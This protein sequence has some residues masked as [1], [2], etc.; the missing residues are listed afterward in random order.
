MSRTS[1]ISLD[2]ETYGIAERT[3]DGRPLPP[4][5]VFHPARAIRTDG[6]TIDDMILT[7]AITVPK[8]DPR[9]DGQWTRK[10]LAALEPAESMPFRMWV[11]AERNALRAWLRQA[12][13]II[14][15]NVL[16]DVLMLRY[17]PDFS[18]QLPLRCCTLIDVLCAS[19]LH[20]ETSRGGLKALGP[21]LNLFSYDEQDLSRCRT[22]ASAASPKLLDYNCQD[23]HN[24]MAALARLASM[25]ERD[26]P[27]TEKLEKD[28][29]AHFSDVIWTCLEMSEA[30]V[31]MDSGTLT[32]LEAQELLKAEIAVR[33][34]RTRGLLLEGEGSQ[35]SQR[36]FVD[37]VL[38]AVGPAVLDCPTLERTEK[39]KQVSWSTHNRHI[40]RS[41][42]LAHDVH[43][44]LVVPL[45]VADVQAAAQKLVSTY[46]H[47]LLHGNRKKPWIRDSTLLP[48]GRPAPQPTS[49]SATRAPRAPSMSESHS[50]SSSRPLPTSTAPLRTRS[51]PGSRSPTSTAPGEAPASRPSTRPARRSS[52]DG[53]P[54]ASSSPPSRGTARARTPLSP[55]RRADGIAFATWYCFPSFPKDGS[56]AEGGTVQSRPAAQKPAVCTF[57]PSVEAAVC[58]RFEGGSL[59]KPDL[60][61][62]EL[63]VAALQSGDAVLCSAFQEGSKVDLHS[64]R[65][66]SIAG[67]EKLV[68]LCGP[69]LVKANPRFNDYRQVGKT[70][71]FAD[72][73]LAMAE[74]MQL[75]AHKMSGIM[76]PIDIF[77]EAVARRHIDRAGLTEW[78]Y[79]TCCEVEK[80]GY[81]VLPFYGQ[82]RT[83]PGFQVDHG[84]F[85]R[86][87]QVREKKAREAQPS[88]HEVVNFPVQAE[89]ANLMWDLLRRMSTLMYRDWGSSLV[90]PLLFRQIYDSAHVDCPPGTRDRVN[91]LWNLS[92]SECASKGYWAR[93]QERFGRTVYLS[94]KVN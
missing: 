35:L 57:P 46:T 28:C 19:I 1:I 49:S 26:W 61:Q 38:D 5:T 13:T 11:P 2:I 88:I 89:A 84:A 21:R 15:A 17:L 34:A 51:R 6:V 37:R 78:Q 48:I 25:V 54:K 65:I 74:T 69:D 45:R 70:V 22:H 23:T 12:D 3:A 14:G 27:D 76:F 24:T 71:N 59:F 7:V 4:Q 9:I 85:H 87:R 29:V 94:Y 47:P 79:R 86:F 67:R 56:G 81:L 93:L 63:R 80:L 41:A 16:F 72:C 82:G 43:T 20:D 32:H 92:V 52:G 90:R 68:G 73:F 91:E 77:L 40:M 44:P 31:P 58:S 39:K 33:V 50:P 66:I 10:A 83:F 53:P 75:Q 8:A 18:V 30:G 64:D 60:D 42:L 55:P 62:I 36:T